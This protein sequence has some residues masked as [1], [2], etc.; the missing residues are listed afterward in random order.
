MQHRLR[1]LAALIAAGAIAAVA[2]QAASAAPPSAPPASGK[3]IVSPIAPG[4]SGQRLT[5]PT[6]TS[7]E[8]PAGLTCEVDPAA[9]AQNSSDPGDYGNFDLASRPSH[10]LGVDYVVIHDTEISFDSTVNEFQNPLAY[11]S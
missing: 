5:P 9:Y 8:C 4:K 7:P 1:T 2:S 11:V 6:L 10:G 3:T